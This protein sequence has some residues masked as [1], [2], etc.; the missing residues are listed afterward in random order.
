MTNQE[1]ELKL[2]DL[3]RRL[4]ILEKRVNRSIGDKDNMI[5]VTCND[6]GFIYEV[7]SRCGM[8][9]G[10]GHNCKSLCHTELTSRVI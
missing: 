4:E 1:L 10:V 6:Y 5:P 7:C 2:I 8:P 3:Q 9:W